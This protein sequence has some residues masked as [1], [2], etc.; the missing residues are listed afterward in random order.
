MARFC[1]VCAT[2][3]NLYKQGLL[4]KGRIMRKK[5]VQPVAK[6]EN[7][8]YN[9]SVVKNYFFMEERLLWMI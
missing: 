7:A 6:S 2:G 8:L 4:E 3:C 9:V 1:V 5:C